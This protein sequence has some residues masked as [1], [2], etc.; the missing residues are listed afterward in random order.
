MFCVNANIAVMMSYLM[1]LPGMG[2]RLFCPHH[3]VITCH[4]KIL[5]PRDSRLLNCAEFLFSSFGND[6]ICKKS[7]HQEGCCS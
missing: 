3:Q 7:V 5:L 4:P 6:K 1:L 2:E